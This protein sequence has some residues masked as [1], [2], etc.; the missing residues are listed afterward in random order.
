VTRGADDNTRDSA[1]GD[2]EYQPD[3]RSVTAREKAPLIGTA[4]SADGAHERTTAPGDTN[5]YGDGPPE[6]VTAD[7][8]DLSDFSA[9]N[10]FVCGKNN[11]CVAKAFEG[12][13]HGGTGYPLHSHVITASERGQS[14]PIPNADLR[15]RTGQTRKREDQ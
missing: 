2:A 10:R 8:F 5:T 6:R 7:S 9:V 11:L 14:G 1:D 15:G 4:T 3:Q 12:S 13:F